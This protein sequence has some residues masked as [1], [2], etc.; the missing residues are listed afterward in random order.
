MIGGVEIARPDVPDPRKCRSPGGAGRGEAWSVEFGLAAESS[1]GTRDRP[2]P[3]PPNRTGGFPASGSPAASLG[4]SASEVGAKL[5]P[6]V[7]RRANFCCTCNKRLH[8]EKPVSG[9]GYLT[10]HFVL[11]SGGPRQPSGA[12]LRRVARDL[13]VP[14]SPIAFR[15]S[16]GAG[17][18]PPGQ[19][20][21]SPG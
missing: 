20:R 14:F 3:L 4:H 13:R 19:I 5:R 21:H 12:W 8:R 1:A 11:H 9:I 16:R 7:A 10:W 15:A 17:A 2:P 6:L 18:S